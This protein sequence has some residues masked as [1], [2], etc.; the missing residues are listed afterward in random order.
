M[1]PPEDVPAGTLFQKLQESPAPSEVVD[2]PRK[3]ADGKPIGKCRIFALGMEDH[4]ECRFEAREWVRSKINAGDKRLNAAD[5]ELLREVYG[6]ATARFLLQKAVREVEPTGGS[7]DM[8][9]GPQYAFVF[10]RPEDLDKVLRAPELE[11]LF[12]AYELI[13][14]K[15]GPF[16][17]NI[18]SDD[19]ITAWVTRLTEGA[20]D[21]P[22]MRCDWLV[23][24]DLCKSLAQRTYCLSAVLESQRSSLPNTTA[25]ALER[26]GIGIGL[27]GSVPASALPVGANRQELS[28][29][30]PEPPSEQS[31]QPQS[32]SDDDPP[33]VPA[34][35]PITI[36]EAAR[37]AA[38]KL[39]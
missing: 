36:E 21:F 33:V 19:E 12:Q 24:A 20:A 14:H 29:A 32:P 9:C 7:A 3:G 39:K 5:D 16:Q 31:P 22:L 37:V 13:Q 38:Q 17:N 26:W 2:F 34:D 27:F 23:L 28:L 18:N 25:S 30:A 1:N 10:M 8:D 6:D 15:Y 4:H 11:T 35:R